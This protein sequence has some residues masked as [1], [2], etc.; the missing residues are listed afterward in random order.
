MKRFVLLFVISSLLY[1][2]IL[3]GHGVPPTPHNAVK[4][5]GTPLSKASPADNYIWKYN[6]ALDSFMLEVDAGA[7][8]GLTYFTE[9]DDNDTSVFTA[10]GPNT[11]VGFND[12]LTM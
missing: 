5:R 10:T 4:V 1:V 2:G 8:G 7:G 9:A 11:T 12:L 6:S 3:L